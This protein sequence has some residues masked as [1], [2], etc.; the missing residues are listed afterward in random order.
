MRT[1]IAAILLMSVAATADAQTSPDG[2]AAC[3][4][5]Q[6]GKLLV[7]TA[8]YTNGYK[9]EAP[10]RVLTITTQTRGARMTATLDYIIETDPVTGKRQ[11]TALPGPIEMTF[12][13]E[14]SGTM[15]EHAAGIWCATVAKALAARSV[16]TM[17][18]VA[19]NRVIM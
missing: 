16:D 19:Q 17:S 3:K 8:E 2:E 13:G 15:L 5:N 7:T 12:N 9:V 6:N 10:W 18:R 14:N 4:A 11:R 1:I